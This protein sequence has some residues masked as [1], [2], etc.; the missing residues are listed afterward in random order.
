MS[1]EES[2]TEHCREKAEFSDNCGTEREDCHIKPFFG[3][4]GEITIPY[5]TE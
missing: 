4:G 5:A 1:R 2:T 3:E